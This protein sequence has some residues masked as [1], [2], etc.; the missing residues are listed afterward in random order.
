MLR[1]IQFSPCE[2]FSLSRPQSEKVEASWKPLQFMSVSL[3]PLI[4]RL[5]EPEYKE[6][7]LSIGLRG[8][9]QKEG[10]HLPERISKKSRKDSGDNGT[11]PS[12]LMRMSQP[13]NKLGVSSI[14]LNFPGIKNESA[15]L[16]LWRQISSKPL[17][18]LSDSW[19]TQRESSRTFFPCPDAHHFPQ[20]NGLISS[21]GKLLTWERFSKLLIPLT[22]NPSKLTSLTTRSSSLSGPKSCPPESF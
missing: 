12:L 16:P 7:S 20:S 14:P 9:K 3:M 8:K 6:M 13:S 21:S 15:P 11:V 22:L 19:L 1:P 18:N 4:D 17:S 5:K 2:K 10:S